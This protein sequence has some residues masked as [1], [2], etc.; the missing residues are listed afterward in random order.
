MLPGPVENLDIFKLH[1]NASPELHSICSIV[2]AASLNGAI[3][4]SSKEKGS[5][6]GK[7]QYEIFQMIPKATS[8]NGSIKRLHQT[9]LS[10]Q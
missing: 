10:L 9:D 5:I 6:D 3:C 8:E 4:M 7:I 1:T 2:F